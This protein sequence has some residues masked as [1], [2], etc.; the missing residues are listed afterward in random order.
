MSQQMCS[1]SAAASGFAHYR[2]QLPLH[3]VH[4]PPTH[5]WKNVSICDIVAGRG[6]G[7]EA[8][9]FNLKQLKPGSMPI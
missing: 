8:Q 2:R 4:P 9:L 3:S 5:S 7:V 1:A 6:G